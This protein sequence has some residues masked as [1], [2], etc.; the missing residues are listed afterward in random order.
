M[1]RQLY[2]V[3]AC[4]LL[5]YSCV[6]IEEPEFRAVENF[7][8]KELGLESVNVGFGLT[9]FNPNNFSVTVKETGADVYLDS[10]MLG[11]LVQ[12]SIVEVGKKNNFTIPLSGKIPLQAFLRMNLKDIHR[13]EILLR[14]DGSTRVGKAGIFI[15]Q[16]V[17]Y[18]GRHRLDQIRL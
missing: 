12:D 7:E 5:L 17:K 18:A 8:V 13:R 2:F 14:A 3:I 16:K 4:A 15:S 10:M 11:R 6:R 9:Y 1:R